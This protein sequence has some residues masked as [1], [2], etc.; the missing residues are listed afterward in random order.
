MA[1]PRR[2]SAT[3]ARSKPTAAKRGVPKP[4][5][6]K[7]SA[8]RT[9]M[10][11]GPGIADPLLARIEGAKHQRVGGATV[12][13]VKAGNGRIKRLVYPPGFRWSTHMQAV[14]GTDL[15][16]H[17]HVGF[18]ARGHIKGEYADGCAFEFVAPQ[19]VAV[20]PG[21]DAWVVGREPA[22]LIQFDCQDDTAQ[23]FGLPEEHSH[24]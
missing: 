16:M 12:D 14:A 17:A 4:K 7:S 19:A 2:S 24:G 22:V 3:R 6:A 13:T 5:I 20:E 21:H 11:A 15:C 1:S 10:A 23:R 9:N 8:A 18:L